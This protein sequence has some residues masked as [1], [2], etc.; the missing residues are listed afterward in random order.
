MLHDYQREELRVQAERARQHLEGDCPLLEDEV[1]IAAWE[2]IQELEAENR[3]I[4][5]LE[6]RVIYLQGHDNLRYI[7][8]KL[9]EQEG[10]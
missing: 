2:Y 7:D 10:E 8:N 1:A 9:S 5:L 3:R 4:K 6:Q